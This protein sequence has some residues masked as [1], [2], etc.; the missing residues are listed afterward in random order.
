M[1]RRAVSCSGSGGTQWGRSIKNQRLGPMLMAVL[2]MPSGEFNRP[3]ALQ[4]K[5]KT[6]IEQA[7]SILAAHAAQAVNLSLTLRNGLIGLYIIESELHGTGNWT[8]IW[9]SIVPTRK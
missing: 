2:L 9:C 7:H 8:P 4:H 3:R 5:A 6:S 1:A